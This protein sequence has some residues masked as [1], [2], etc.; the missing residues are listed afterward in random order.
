MVLLNRILVGDDDNNHVGA[1]A[2][3]CVACCSIIWVASI[4]C[5]AG[6]LIFI[7]V[8]VCRCLGICGN[9]RKDVGGAQGPPIYGTMPAP[10]GNDLVRPPSGKMTKPT[11][12]GNDLTRPP[13]TASRSTGSGR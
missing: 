2:K 1:A 10:V 4:I 8:C 7:G 6:I 3:G 5:L 12:V 13:S 11:P 9:K